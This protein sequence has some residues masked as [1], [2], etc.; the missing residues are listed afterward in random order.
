MKIEKLNAQP[1]SLEDIDWDVLGYVSKVKNQGNCDAGYA[2]STSSLYES[3]L[4]YAKK[5]ITLSEQQFVDCGENYTMMGCSG[6]S[7]LG[8]INYTNDKGLDTDTKYPWTGKK[9]TC[10]TQSGENKFTLKMLQ[11]DGCT[12]VRNLLNKTPQTIAVNTEN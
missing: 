8:A 7:R 12:E 9:G 3:S 6:G 11:A 5:N 2:F 10:Q 1:S 4:L